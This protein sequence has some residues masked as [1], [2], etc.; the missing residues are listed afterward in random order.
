MIAAHHNQVEAIYIIHG[1]CTSFGAMETQAYYY[2]GLGVEVIIDGFL[3]A[4]A[5]SMP[6]AGAGP[7]LRVIILVWWVEPDSV[8]SVSSTQR[9]RIVVSPTLPVTVINP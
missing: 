4:P 7:K 8:C 1:V 9:R 3:K 5:D 2:S 6:P